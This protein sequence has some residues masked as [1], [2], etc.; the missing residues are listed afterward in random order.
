MPKVS[1]VMPSL[2]VRPYIEECLD[3]VL[4]QSLEDIEVLCVDAG[5]TDGTLELLQRYAQKDA[6]IRV[7]RSDRKSYGYQMNLGLDAACGEYFGIVETDDYIAPEMYEQLYARARARQLDILKADYTVF[8][9]DGARRQFIPCRIAKSRSQYGK[10]V[11]PAEDRSA[12]DNTLYTWSGIYR[13]AFLKENGIRHNETPGA[14]YQDNGFWFQTF[15]L[16][17]RVSFLPRRFYFLRRDNP[18]SSVF[19]KNKVYAECVEYDFIRDFLRRHPELEPELAPVC[20]YHRC[21]NYFGTLERIAEEDKP[22]F[23][24]RFAEDFR[25]IQAAGELDRSLFPERDWDALRAIMEEPEAYYTLKKEKAL[26]GMSRG[27]LEGGLRCLRE[28]GAAYTI[29][30]ML[31]GRGLSR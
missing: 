14:S 7:I 18:D 31:H 21:R 22:G 5:S 17:E 20:A 6:R 9:G 26:P 16:A 8:T 12:F 25:Q 13:T 4:N 24:Q 30:Y 27:R 10:V 1:I 23:L 3:S 15:A 29:Q 19:A 2:N 11:R 28:H